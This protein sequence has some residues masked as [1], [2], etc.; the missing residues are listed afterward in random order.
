MVSLGK[1]SNTSV[2][3]VSSKGLIKAKKDGIVSITATSEDGEYSKS[4]LV[5]VNY[6]GGLVIEPQSIKIDEHLD[7][8][9]SGETI[10]IGYKI[11][12]L[13]TTDKDVTVKIY[14]GDSKTSKRDG[15]YEFT[16]Y[17][18]GRYTVIFTTDNKLSDSTTFEVKS[19][20]KGIEIETETLERDPESQRFVLYHG[21]TGQLDHI[22]E[23]AKLTS[24]IL[25]DD[26]DWD[27]SDSKLLSV[28]DDGEFTAKKTRRCYY[29][30]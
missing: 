27:S 7:T 13:D 4:A 19:N 17:D 2:A 5:T 6:N 11:S 14:G 26:V 25:V 3:T 23:K 8:I 16:C 12:P 20:L 21:Q 10:M 30:G 22:F 28:N 29:K 1:S 9:Q 15:Y 24:K 18:E